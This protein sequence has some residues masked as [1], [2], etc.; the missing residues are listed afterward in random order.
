MR[1][2]TLSIGDELLCGETVDTN[3][4]RI[5]GLLFEA[6]LGVVRHLT[7]ADDENAIATA[8]VELAAGFDQVVVTGGLG[9]TPDDLTAA[10]AARAAGVPLEPS[11]QALAHLAAFSRRIPGGLHPANDRQA[12]VPRGSSLIPNPLGTACGF[13]LRLAGARCFFLPGVPF[14]RE[15]MLQESVLPALLE[16]GG[17]G[18]G[19]RATL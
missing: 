8:L 5:A 10:A 14:E 7:V 4:S 11:A 15:R 12:L 13:T 18:P 16:A 9:P 1:L 19:L 6:G 3:Q 2:A 17:T